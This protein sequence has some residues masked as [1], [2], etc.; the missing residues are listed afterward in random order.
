MSKLI[1]L[2][3]LLM[4]VSAF[5]DGKCVSTSNKN[6]TAYAAFIDISAE[7]IG[8]TGMLYAQAF[9]SGQP[10]YDKDT[11]RLALSRADNFLNGDDNCFRLTPAEAK[12]LTAYL[13]GICGYM[14]E[15]NLIGV[16]TDESIKRL[17]K[18]GAVKLNERYM[19]VA[20]QIIAVK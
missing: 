18:S 10:D 14:M 7:V 13:R 9:V 19:T 15:Q 12:S 2:F 16:L 8:D 20:K 3:I 4:S 6:V 17:G 5:A 11:F 1:T